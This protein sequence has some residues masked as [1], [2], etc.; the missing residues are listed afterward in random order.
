MAKA[1]VREYEVPGNTGRGTVPI[2]QEPGTDQPVVTFAGSTAS[3]AFANRTKFIRFIADAAFH[4]VVATNPTATTDALRVPA[5]TLIEIG[6]KG[7]QKIAFIAA[8]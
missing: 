4:Y 2:P 3:A 6:V 5:D 8:A 7:G 1:W